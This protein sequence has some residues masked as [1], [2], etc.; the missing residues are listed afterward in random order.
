M[1]IRVRYVIAATVALATAGVTALTL[2]ASASP[3]APARH[4]AAAAPRASALP[5]HVLMGY[6]QDFT[7]GAPVLKLSQVP[8]S[9]GLVAA[10]FSTQTTTPGQVAFFIDK[11]I[12]SAT[13]FKA[14]VKTLEARGQHVI[15]SVGGALGNVDVLNAAEA[16]EFAKS[17]HYMMVKWGFQG[18]DIDLEGGVNPT[19][20]AS[21]LQQ[22]RAL[23]GPNLIIT[24][25]PQTTDVYNNSSDYYVLALKI[26]DILTMMNV[27][28]YNTSGAWDCNNNLQDVG[29]ENILTGL[30]CALIHGSPL[31]AGG[32]SPSQIGVGLPASPSAAGGYQSPSV[33]NDAMDCIAALTHCGSFVP[34]TAYPAI[35][36]VMTWD[37]SWDA[38]NGYNFADTVAPHLATLP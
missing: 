18:V 36:G 19:F 38:A 21:A 23:A 35:R 28:Y 2:P 37:I 12:E 22:L 13:Q 8:K 25:A 5:A 11:A 26:K 15:L 16:T 10:A 31:I 9:Y 32:L 29:T 7:N 14:D 24:M 27:Q 30:T 17:M 1:S 6:W 20:M 3:R 34:P 4:H 33:V